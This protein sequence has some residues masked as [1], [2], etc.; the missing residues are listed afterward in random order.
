MHDIIL[1]RRTIMEIN[2]VLMEYDNMFGSNTLEEIDEYLV[3]KIQE[4]LSEGDYYSAITLMNEIIGFSRD[5]SQKEKGL[6]YCELV[7]RL[8]EKL[9]ITDTV[10]YATSMIN[11]ANAYRAF[12]VYDEAMELYHLVENVYREKLPAGEFN[13]ASLYNN[14]SL[15]YQELG[16]FE[17]SRLMLMKAMSVV[18]MHKQA[19]IE[20][21]NTRTNLAVTLLRLSMESKDEDK[22]A[23]YYQE[24]INYLKIALDVF[25]K[26]GG[27]DFHYSAA[28]SAMGDALYIA[29]EYE[30]GASYYEHALKELEKHVGKSDA[31]YR[32]KDNY[33]KTLEM[34]NN[35][36]NKSETSV[37]FSGN[38]ARCKAFY[39]KYGAPMIHDR[40]PE[41]ES[42]IAVGMVGEGS[43]CFGFDDDISTDHDYTLGFCMWLSGEDYERIGI[44]LNKAYEELVEKHT[45]EF[46]TFEGAPLLHG[47]FNKFIDERRGV[48]TIGRFY[49][50]TIG[51]RLDEK[52]YNRV[53]SVI[54]NQQWYDIEENKLATAV[55][56]EVFRD[57]AGVFTKIRNA[58]NEYYPKKVWM[59]KLSCALHD[60]AQYAQSNYSRMMA[61]R[62]YVSANLCVA[63]GMESAMNIAYLLNRCYAPYYKWMRKGMDNLVVLKKLAPMLDEIA[64]LGSQNEAWEGK[65]YNPYELNHDDRVV[66]IFEQ[67]AVAILEELRLQEIVDGNDTFLDVYCKEL[68][69]RALDGDNKLNM[70]MSKDELVDS[71]VKLEWEQFDKV[72]NEGGRADCQD[73]WGT[74]RIMRQSQ[75]MAWTEELL[76]SYYN[77][78]VVANNTGWNLIMEKYARMMK[79]TAPERYEELKKD[80]PLRS[81]EREKIAEE[82]IKIQVAWMEDFAEKYPHMAGNARS[83]HTYEDSAYNTSYETYLRG[84]LGTYSEETFVLYGRFIAS[85]NMAGENLAYNIMSNTAKLYG[86]ESVEVAEQRLAGD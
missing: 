34:I 47:N 61:R 4:A 1:K 54:S 13:Y 62:D 20:Q 43:D 55:N 8:F 45:E 36:S 15:L 58:I 52:N 56:G 10:E 75:Y 65:K 46:E 7:K 6:H 38:L 37:N 31:Y 76:S 84:E 35:S 30:E 80:L 70:K 21:A 23:S 39:E 41:Y 71:I 33:E 16:D 51:I 24:A 17:N 26:D 86:Y 19:Y 67:I 28:L 85:T 42:R 32:V 2:K 79:S 9:G 73:N 44:S 29:G 57:D 82:I 64:A 50:K 74:F 66:C 18:D 69:E 25:E 77:D 40:F 72:K 68:M 27:R 78:L 3:N 49:E 83:I 59:L 60:F 12:E 81:E 11:I 5:T 48:C 22:K 14:W 63:K 53:S